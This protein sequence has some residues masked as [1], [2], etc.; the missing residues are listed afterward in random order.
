MHLAPLFCFCFVCLFVCLFVF[1]LNRVYLLFEEFVRKKFSICLN[2]RFY[3]LSQSRAWSVARPIFRESGAAVADDVYPETK[4]NGTQSTIC[5]CSRKWK[6]KL[7][8]Q[9]FLGTKT[10]LFCLRIISFSSLESGLLSFDSHDSEINFD[11][12]RSTTVKSLPGASRA[13]C[14][15]SSDNGKDLFADELLV[16]S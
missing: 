7:V 14:N 10:S 5:I 8:A 13:L 15:N 1:L 6:T 9:V 4:Q 2:P 16:E 12:A 11:R 3:L